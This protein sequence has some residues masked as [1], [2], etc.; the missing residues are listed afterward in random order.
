MENINGVTSW[1]ASGGHE[2]FWSGV[3]KRNKSVPSAGLKGEFYSVMSV[4]ARQGLITGRRQRGK[5]IMKVTGQA[6]RAACDAAL[7]AIDA[8]IEALEESG[9][10]VAWQDDRGRTGSQL[11]I[12]EYSPGVREYAADGTEAWQFYTL[13]V[14]ELTG[15]I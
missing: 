4:G 7:G 1:L 11:V 5:A 14:K 3:I 13:T 10:P 6:S 8:E 9:T 2:W 15:T 12:D